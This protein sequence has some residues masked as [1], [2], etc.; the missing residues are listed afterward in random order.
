[1]PS[2]STHE[3]INLTLLTVII[4]IAAYAKIP[5]IYTFIFSSAYIF[6][7]YLLSPDL[8]VNSKIY[9]RWRLLKILWCPYKEAFKHRQAS[10]H[11]IWGP[12]SLIG[13]LGLMILLPVY[14]CGYSIDIYDVRLWIFCAGLTVA[15][16][17]HIISDKIF[18]NRKPKYGETKKPK[19][20]V[21]WS[22]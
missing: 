12:I 16:E 9:K 11:I 1:M 20:G 22:D 5:Y 15:I 14:A 21:G 8:D 6:S 17:I 7:T 19:Y 10:H 13:C 18:R 3:R 4:M 2:H